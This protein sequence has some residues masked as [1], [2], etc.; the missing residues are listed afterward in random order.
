MTALILSLAAALFKALPEI[1]SLVKDIRAEH[2]QKEAVLQDLT[3]KQRY[4]VKQQATSNAIN[5]AVAHARDR[6]RGNTSSFSR[7]EVDTTAK[8]Q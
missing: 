7:S 3:A 5:A 4:E 8:Q 6:V 1:V 2:K